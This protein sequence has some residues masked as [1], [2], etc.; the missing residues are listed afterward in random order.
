MRYEQPGSGVA[1]TPILSV[2]GLRK[3]YGDQTVVDDLGFSV[4]RGQC[5]GLLGPNGAGKTTSLRMLLGMTMPDAGTVLLCNERV[6]EFA[7]RARM[8]VGVVPQFDNLDP[9]FSVS[10]NLRIFGRYF[11]LSGACLL[12][13]SDAAD[14]CCGV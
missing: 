1:S 10:E 13:T 6:P 5:F 14:E 4:R 3:R 2:D 7:H 8:R 11:G 12:Y 9:D